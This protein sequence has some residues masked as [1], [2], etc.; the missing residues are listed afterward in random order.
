LIVEVFSPSTGKRDMNEKFFL[1][2]KSGVSEY[3]VVYPNDKAVTVFLLKDGKYNKGTTYDLI[4][5]A[6]KV[7]V[8][9]LK[10]LVIDLEEL[11]E[12]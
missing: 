9:T 10:G 5:G 11:F 7:P 12:D 2:E 4:I 3:W 1:Y 8:K 6:K